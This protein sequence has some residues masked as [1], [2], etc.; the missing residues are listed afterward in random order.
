MISINWPGNPQVI[1]CFEV[2][3]R[4]AQ[5]FLAGRA[6]AA[7]DRPRARLLDG[8]ARPDK[9]SI[10]LGSDSADLKRPS[11][12]LRMSGPASGPYRQGDLAR[13]PSLLAVP[14]CS[15]PRWRARRRRWRPTSRGLPAAGWWCCHGTGHS[16][17]HPPMMHDLSR[18]TSNFP[19][20]QASE[21]ARGSRGRVRET[22]CRNACSNH[23]TASGF[24]AWY[25]MSSSPMGRRADRNTTCRPRP[26]WL[27]ESQPSVF[28]ASAC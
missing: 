18:G 10:T 11:L 14:V 9:E 27:L 6:K 5:S 17:P 23:S 15:L 24:P 2:S 20:V 8:A 19:P 28:L 3:G 25:Y 7:A 13:R 1:H 4:R 12:S 16:T 21:R 22:D 26:Y